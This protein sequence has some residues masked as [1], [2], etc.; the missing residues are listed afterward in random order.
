MNIPKISLVLISLVVLTSCNS[1]ENLVGS[2][3]INN[4]SSDSVATIFSSPVHDALSKT[5]NDI[6][7]E[8]TSAK[9]ISTGMEIGI[10]YTAPDNG[11]WRPMPGHLFY[12]S[13]EVYP[14]EIEFASDEKLANWEKYR[15]ALCLDSLSY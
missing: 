2:E 14:D 6:T 5:K 4:G 11:E 3:K 7:V 10:C 12:G 15:N 8:I 9:A 1:S 13:Y